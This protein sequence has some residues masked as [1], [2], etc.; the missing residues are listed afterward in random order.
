MS[1]HPLFLIAVFDALR[2]DMVTPDLAPNLSRFMAEGSN[3]PLSR[4]VFPTATRV[5]ATAL[6]TGAMPGTH[7]IVSN[8]FFDPNVFRDQLVHTGHAEQ[9]DAAQA[10]YGG[11][12]V[13]TPS[14][15]EVAAAAGYKVAVVSSG[16]TGLT[17]LANP[18]AGELGHVSLSL[19][20]WHTSTP[21]HV[22]DPLLREFGPIPP[23]TRPN[24]AH[25]GLQTDIFLEAVFPRYGPDVSILWFSD[26][27]YTYHHCG[28]GSAESL[29]AIR[30]VDAQF[31]R[32]LEWWQ[33][34]DLH[35]RLQVIALSDH[36]QITAR[37]KIDV[38]E[39]A[40]RAGLRIAEHFN[41]GADYAGS[42]GYEGSVVVRDGDRR[43]TAA[44][45]E[46]LAEQPWCGMIFTTGGNGIEGSVSGT[47]DHALLVLDHE[48][49]PH[50][51]YVMLND[52]S[53][54]ANGIV[55][56]C[57][58]NGEMPE[59]GG[60]HG[61]LHPKELDNVLSARG[62][63]FKEGFDSP[64]PAGVIDV[65]PTI[66]HLMGLRRPEGMDGRVLSEALAG[67]DAEP[68]A[69]ETVTRSVGRGERTQHLRFSRVGSTK[70]L[71]AGWIE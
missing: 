28:V 52:D 32:I 22:A 2:P 62:S 13:T 49:T 61:G 70:Y 43:H 65:A 67:T 16:S 23:A 20:G 15:G 7:G 14:L 37:K 25:V 8:K 5:N 41:D 57:F 63:L 19:R 42:A 9:V 11:R 21:S 68:P 31:G 17:R 29:E 33:G 40:S 60:I 66:L 26:P 3:F 27:D 4:A 48:R 24:T 55:G 45:V 53:I 1:T 35:D 64:Y 54:D 39:E 18:K 47:F 46:W 56:S 38:N 36:G 44:L 34:S 69:P 12:L 30:N 6:A 50:V 51:S 58:Y 10:A 59:G 71:D